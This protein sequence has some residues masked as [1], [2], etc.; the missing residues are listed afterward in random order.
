M[1]KKVQADVKKKSEIDPL[2]NK[3]SKKFRLIFILLILTTGLV[4]GWSL[5]YV[6]YSNV[7]PRSEFV[8]M[9]TDLHNRNNITSHKEITQFEFLN[10]YVLTSVYDKF[11]HEELTNFKDLVQNYC[12]EAKKDKS[13]K[14]ISF[15]FR[16]MITGAWI[17]INE[18]EKFVPA[19][20]TKVPILIA[21]FQQAES[22]PEYLRKKLTYKGSKAAEYLKEHP[23]IDDIRTSM[24]PYESYT[25]EELV[26]L[27]ITKSDNEAALLLLNDIGTDK[28]MALQKRLGNSVPLNAS[29]SNNIITVKSYSAFFRILYNASLLSRE[30]SD[31][32]LEILSRSEYD[33]GIRMA[34]PSEI[35]ICH[36]YG[37]RD[38]LLNGNILKIQQLHHAAIVYYPGKP[39]FICIMTKGSDKKKMEKIIFDIAKL[40]YKQVDIQVKNFPKPDL[41]KDID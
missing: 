10:P 28:W 40:S 37:E 34:V 30:Y 38:T 24:Q 1:S 22:N 14:Q 13:I 39:F 8:K 18:K 2:Q 41:S 6:I 25:I 19:S 4:I 23:E 12:L 11:Y 3:K 26:D 27:M 16:D 21:I 9:N 5:N 32:A 15:Y 35:R 17:G 29:S 36:K 33:K 31:K 7:I 20:L